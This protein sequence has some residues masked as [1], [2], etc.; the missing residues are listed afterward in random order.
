VIYLHHVT[1]TTGHSRRSSRADASDEAIAAVAAWIQ[2]ALRQPGPVPLMPPFGDYVAQALTTDGA[3]VVTLYGRAPQVGPRLPLVSMA[4]AT[5]SRHGRDLWDVLLKGAP[6]ALPHLARPP[7]PWCAV[8]VHPTA[9]SDLEALSW[10]AD[11]ELVVAWAWIT[12]HPDIRG[13]A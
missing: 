5:R 4:V 11:F 7:A 9:P 3:L 13:V 2:A 1:I 6:R 12:R 8:T 10:A